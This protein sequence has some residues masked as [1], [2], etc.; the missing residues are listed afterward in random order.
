MAL[1]QTGDRL[2]PALLN[3]I[4]LDRVKAS[5]GT[6]ATTEAVE[7]TATL[8][9]PASWNTYDVDVLVMVRCLETGIATGNTTVTL[10]VRK[11]NT[12][13]TQWGTSAA[14]VGDGTTPAT[15]LSNTC[16]GAYAEGETTTGTVNIVFTAVGNANN[17]LI[18]W[19]DLVMLAEAKR[20][21]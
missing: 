5:G 10:R 21:S 19:A 1:I 4:V 9:I 13:G 14:I 6:I 18:S 15:N 20:T 3:S 7:A 16:F 17:G 11:T 8:S 2:T 12:S